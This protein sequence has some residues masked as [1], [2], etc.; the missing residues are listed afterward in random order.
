MSQRNVED[1][2]FHETNCAETVSEALVAGAG[3]FMD[4]RGFDHKLS[5]SPI[6]NM[7]KSSFIDYITRDGALFRTKFTL[8]CS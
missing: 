4:S 3:S 1:L 6:S 5:M 2:K 8:P 7:S